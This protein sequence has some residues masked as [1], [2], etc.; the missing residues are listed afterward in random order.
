MDAGFISL[1]L[2]VTMLTLLASGIWVAPTLLAV[3]FIALEFFSPAPAGSLLASTVWDASW[4]WALTAL[5]LFVWMGEI[6]FRTR[7]SSDMF[8][9]LAPWLTRHSQQC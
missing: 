8:N 6:L 9:G 3:G 4:N 5:P 7:L 1:I 2:F